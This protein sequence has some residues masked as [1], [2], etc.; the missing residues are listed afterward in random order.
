MQP[1]EPDANVPPLIYEI[2]SSAVME[3]NGESTW[4]TMTPS[5]YNRLL[6]TAAAEVEDDLSLLHLLNAKYRTFLTLHP[7]T[8]DF[9]GFVLH[10]LDDDHINDTIDGRENDITFMDDVRELLDLLT[11]GTEEG[12]FRILYVCQFIPFYVHFILCRFMLFYIHHLSLFINQNTSKRTRK[13]HTIQDHCR[14]RRPSI[15]H[16]F[17][18]GLRP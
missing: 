14:T 4:H 8:Y 7:R 10:L 11:T 15:S 5:T 9:I 2:V 12:V 16:I 6:Y 17:S 18:N 1:K 3:L 13:E